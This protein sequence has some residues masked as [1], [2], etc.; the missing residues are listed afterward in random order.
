MAKPGPS[1]PA[2]KT[3]SGTA[4]SGANKPLSGASKISSLLKS[5]ISPPATR[6]WLGQ[7]SGCH[8]LCIAYLFLPITVNTESSKDQYPLPSLARKPLTFLPSDSKKALEGAL[9]AAAALRSGAV[10]HAWRR[11]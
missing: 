5:D 9:T 7:H 6:P 2:E 8:N 11:Q 10:F 1:M 4:D 3:G